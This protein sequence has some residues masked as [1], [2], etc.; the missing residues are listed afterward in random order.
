MFHDDDLMKDNYVEKMLKLIESDDSLVAV[1]CNAN[2]IMGN[3]KT[4][5]TFIKGFYGL[6]NIDRYEIFLKH[7]LKISSYGPAPF[8]SYLYRMS[9]IGNKYLQENQGGK[10]SDSSFLV[11]LLM[12]GNIVWSLEPYMWYRIHGENGNKQSS[13]KDRLSWFR[14]LK[15][16]DEIKN[17]RFLKDFKF[18]FYFEWY[19]E[20][21]I[22]KGIVFP[23]T[24]KEKVIVK[25]LIIK[26]II[27]ALTNFEIWKILINKITK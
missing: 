13:L 27:T 20:N 2:I 1:G 19:R 9:M 4:K 16:L 6:V 3:I 21:K 5:K 23:R 11:N 18:L 25:F 15:S 12:N 8:P 10:Y 14:W 24:K 17:S 22:K 26:G 7:Y